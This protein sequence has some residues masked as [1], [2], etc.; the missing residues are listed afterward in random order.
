MGKVRN[1]K[2]MNRKA[3]TP[4]MIV[5]ASIKNQFPFTQM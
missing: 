3:T 2:R 5:P 1:G 4:T